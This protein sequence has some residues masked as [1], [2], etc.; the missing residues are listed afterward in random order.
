LVLAQE[1]AQ[2]IDHAKKEREVDLIGA[3]MTA[4]VP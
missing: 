3:V 4:E 1:R 2:K